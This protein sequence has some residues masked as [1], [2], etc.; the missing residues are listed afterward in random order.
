MIVGKVARGS[1]GMSGDRKLG[2]PGDLRES[3]VGALRCVQC[4]TIDNIGT[5]AHVDQLLGHMGQVRHMGE[6]N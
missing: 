1:A 6:D 2:G 5:I 4:S 3:H